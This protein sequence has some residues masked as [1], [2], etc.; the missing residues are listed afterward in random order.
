[1]SMLL[2]IKIHTCIKALLTPVDFNTLILAFINTPVGAFLCESY[3]SFDVTPANV[4][5]ETIVPI[6]VLKAQESKC[7]L[8][9][10]NP[11]FIYK[12]DFLFI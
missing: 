2:F 3:R 9:Q 10:L 4:D 5:D 12:W 7:F 8:L 6:R 1:M 11:Y